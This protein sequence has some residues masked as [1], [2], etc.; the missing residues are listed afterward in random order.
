MADLKKVYA[1]VDEETALYELE[2]FAT[3]WDSNILKFQLHGR[4]IGLNFQPILSIR[5]L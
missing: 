1:A 4:L 2:Q 3:K 5:N